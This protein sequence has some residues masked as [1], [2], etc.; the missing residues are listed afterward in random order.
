MLLV[1]NNLL[2][3]DIGLRIE[4]GGMSSLMK[5]LPGTPVKPV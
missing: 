3:N 2:R 1:M 4:F 5:V